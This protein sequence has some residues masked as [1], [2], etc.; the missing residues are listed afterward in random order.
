M[1]IL[2]LTEINAILG[3]VSSCLISLVLELLPC[4]VLVELYVRQAKCM[5]LGK[6]H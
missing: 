2:F 6:T 5:C 4:A 1:L 3:D